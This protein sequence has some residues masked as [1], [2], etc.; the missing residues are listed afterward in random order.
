MR[1]EALQK[2]GVN[3]MGSSQRNNCNEENSEEKAAL[4]KGPKQ[5]YKTF[6]AIAPPRDSFECGCPSAQPEKTQTPKY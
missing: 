4:P 3:A 1:R 5:E 6:A 2:S